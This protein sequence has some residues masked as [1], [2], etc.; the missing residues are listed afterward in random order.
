MDTR[1]AAKFS[2]LRIF[3]G[4][5]LIL[6]KLFNYG[7]ANHFFVLADSAVDIPHANRITALSYLKFGRINFSRM[8]RMKQLIM[9]SAAILPFGDLRFTYASYITKDI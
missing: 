4:G 1:D 8:T 3:S 2:R 9:L 7:P 6:R 5:R